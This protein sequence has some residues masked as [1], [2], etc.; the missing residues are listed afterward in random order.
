MELD[1]TMLDDVKLQVARP[2]DFVGIDPELATMGLSAMGGDSPNKLFIGGLPTY[3]NDE[4]VMELLK[5]F[6]EL[7]SFN[8]VKEGTGKEQISK[9]S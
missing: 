5:S 2:K 8:L 3:L 1:G 6:G 7:K 9:V 4:Q